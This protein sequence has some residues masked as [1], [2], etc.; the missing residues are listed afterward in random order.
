MRVGNPI[1]GL[2]PLPHSLP[3]ELRSEVIR[4]NSRGGFLTRLIAISVQHCP[5]VAPERLASPLMS[6]R[7]VLLPATEQHRQWLGAQHV[8]SFKELG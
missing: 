5:G 4:S 3:S 6:D 2:D 1:A 7:A 8:R